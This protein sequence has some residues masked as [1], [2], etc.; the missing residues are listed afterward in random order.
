MRCMTLAI[1][2]TALGWIAVIAESRG[3]EAPAIDISSTY[4]SRITHLASTSGKLA[5]EESSPSD[6]AAP[7]LQP[8]AMPGNTNVVPEASMPQDLLMVHGYRSPLPFG[9]SG[10]SSMLQYLTCDPHSCPNIWQGYEAQRAA[11][12]AQK[13]AAPGGGCS[14]G[15]CGIVGGTSLYGSACIDCATR[16]RKV[17]N[18]YRP[19][20]TSGCTSCGSV[21]CDSFGSSNGAL[22]S[23][24]GALGCSSCQAAVK[25]V[26]SGRLSEAPTPA[27]TR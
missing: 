27:T 22:G 26:D 13:C 7:P 12:L 2:F 20:S 10:P 5:A 14:R 9:P 11:E 1:A 4:S 8:Q 6:I 15:G 3:D 23:S 16:P 19:A 25:P 24:N 21:G 18:R 17:V